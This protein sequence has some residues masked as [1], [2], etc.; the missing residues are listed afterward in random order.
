MGDLHALADP[1]TWPQLAHALRPWLSSQ[2]WF[3][4]KAHTLDAV[5]V[6]DA[7]VLGDD[8]ALLVLLDVAYADAEAERY[9]VVLS[10]G[11][12]TVV[13]VAGVALGD[14]LTD[15]AACRTLAE[16][17]LRSGERTTTGGA[18]VVGHPVSAPDDVDLGR[19]RRLG[20]EQSNTSVVLGDRLIL[21]VFRRLEEGLNPDVELTRALTRGGFPNTPP[22]AGAFAL[23][24]PVEPTYLGVIS[25][26]LA[27]AREGW[28][29]A[30]AEAQRVLAGAGAPELVEPMR[31]L[32]TVVGRMHVVL[33]DALGAEEASPDDADGWSRSLQAQAE[34]VLALA[35]RVDPE[36][37][38][39]LLDRRAELLD[40]FT[41]L[42]E[43]ADLGLLVRTHGDL[44]LGQ[45]LLDPASG[46]QVLD[47]EGEPAR[48]LAE[49]RRR[50]TPLR[51]VAGVVR[52]F[53]YAAASAAL[54]PP[55]PL[56][57]W[58][59]DLRTAFLEGYRAVAEPA[60]LVPAAAWSPLL[61]AFELDKAV[62]E[63]GYE[64]ANRPTWVPIPVAGIL[65]VLEAA[66]APDRT[67]RS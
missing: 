15:D 54:E 20:V 50:Q 59:D 44:H 62:Y 3:A 34:R 46:W 61:A 33:R 56:A 35:A 13:E 60:G 37:T 10:T 28:D 26:F 6:A 5:A 42:A 63:L 30:T 22:Q 36:A 24:G 58:R 17:A 66:P 1:D 27:G 64:L 32:G 48:P 57:A 11:A 12:A 29:L 40:R 53:D 14:A 41:G 67:R 43:L 8:A 18:R 51:D 49:R 7:A 9:Q 31:D 55:P 2:R 4:G 19:V 47:F 16:V 52:S 39:P 21:K 65:R 23:E 45:V 38:A 25:A